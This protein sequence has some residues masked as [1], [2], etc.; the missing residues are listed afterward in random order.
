MGL[1]VVRAI[2]PQL[3]PLSFAH[4]ARFLAHPRLYDAPRFFGRDA[5]AEAD[6]NPFP[7]PFA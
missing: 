6:L 2:I 3:M 4:R 5:L 1:T 7:Q